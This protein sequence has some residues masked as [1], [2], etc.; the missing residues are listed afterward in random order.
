MSKTDLLRLVADCGNNTW[1][2]PA[3]VD[4]LRPGETPSLYFHDVPI[5]DVGPWLARLAADPQGS[6]KAFDGFTVTRWSGLYLGTVV[7][8]RLYRR[9]P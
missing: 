8:V 2:L 4:G 1:T 6:T 7:D 9:A 5:A 3:S